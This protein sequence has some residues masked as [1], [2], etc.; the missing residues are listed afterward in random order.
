[1]SALFDTTSNLSLYSIPVAW[2]LSILPHSYAITRSSS[3]DNRNPREYSD[4]LDADKN[5]DETT[6]GRI[7]RAEAA[8][9]NG[10]EN[11]G[12]FAAAVVAGNVAGLPARTLNLLSGGY[13]VSRAVYNF[14][15]INATTQTIGHARS[16]V[17]TV[18][19]VNIMTLFIKS[20]NILKD[21]AANLL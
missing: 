16:A 9:M 8:Q 11:I 10:L 2:V 1:M 6:K 7:L 13:L 5:I 20:G 15:Y 18:G 14:L 21:K 19:I 17:Y 4:N 12:L 3:F